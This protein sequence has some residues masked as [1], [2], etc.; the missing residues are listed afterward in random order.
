MGHS[1]A[2]SI[3]TPNETQW[4][5]RKKSEA[6]ISNHGKIF[7]DS[8]VVMGDPK[9]TYFEVNREPERKAPPKQTGNA[10]AGPNFINSR[11]MPMAYKVYDLNEKFT[12][13]KESLD[14]PKRY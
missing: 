5:G 13:N 11:A 4:F 6:D 9:Q 7:T 2:N 10:A 1:R 12:I 3:A 14:Q 8:Q